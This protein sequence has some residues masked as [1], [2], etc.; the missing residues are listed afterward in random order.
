MPW[1]KSRTPCGA[2]W[3]RALRLLATESGRTRTEMRLVRAAAEPMQPRREGQRHQVPERVQAGHHRHIL[4]R[5]VPSAFHDRAQ[6]S[7]HEARIDLAR[8]AML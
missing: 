7:R 6:E 5:D 2:C 4:A 3:R 8:D 1:Y